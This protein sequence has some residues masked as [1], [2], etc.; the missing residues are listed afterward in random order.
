MTGPPE[1]DPLDSGVATVGFAGSSTS[2][3]I[4]SSMSSGDAVETEDELPPGPNIVTV[5]TDDDDPCD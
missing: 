5:F 4:F 1:F 2:S 3:R